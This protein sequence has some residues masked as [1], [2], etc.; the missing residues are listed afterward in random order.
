MKS[1]TREPSSRSHP[2]GFTLVE[3]LVVIGI[4]AILIGVLLP[5]LANVRGQANALKCQA[6]LRQMGQA[7][8]MYVTNSKQQY[9]PWGIAPRRLEGGQA[10]YQRW[11]ETLSLVLHPRDKFDETYGQPPPNPARPRVSQIF[12]DTD[13]MEGGVCHYTV[14]SRAMPEGGDAPD[15]STAQTDLS[16]NGPTK[17]KKITQIKPSAETA[18][19]WCSQQSSFAATHPLL[20]YTAFSTSR[21]MD[22]AYDTRG[23]FYAA[24]FYFIRGL[25]PQY[26]EERILCAFEQ[27]VAT[28]T[29]QGSFY[30]V[31]TRHQR[32]KRANLLFVDGHVE[33]KLATEMYR[34]L[35]CVN[36]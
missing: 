33:S 19:V 13:T 27:D 2:F 14:N 34:K 20:K 3:L 23:D 1:T 25:K 35:F 22:P 9:L 21:Y 30:G 17:L 16:F 5:T 10:Y 24:G 18:L 28:S 12:K 7:I 29:A 26:E 8:H 31:R 11:Y 36:E 15:G 6:N 4:I 32:N